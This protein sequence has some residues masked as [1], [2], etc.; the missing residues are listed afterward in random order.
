MI[1][2]SIINQYDLKEIET[3]N[4]VKVLKD[5]L[6]SSLPQDSLKPISGAKDPWT[7]MISTSNIHLCLNLYSRLKSVKLY[8]KIET[9]HL[10]LFA[11]KTLM[12]W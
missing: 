8:Q 9:V 1:K 6:N 2:N 7:K 10:A 3:I 4:N 11:Q 5:Y 12:A